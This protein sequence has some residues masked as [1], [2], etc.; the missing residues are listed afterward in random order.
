MNAPTPESK[1]LAIPALLSP[2]PLRKRKSVDEF[3]I[4]ALQA[5][6]LE[7]EST[8]S[9]QENTDYGSPNISPV[10]PDHTT[11]PNDDD[12]RS[13]KSS[14]QKTIE[15]T[16]RALGG[17]GTSKQIC[18]YISNHFPSEIRGKRNWKST[19]RTR[20]C[21]FF[22]KVPDREGEDGKTVWTLNDRSFDDL[23]NPSKAR[24][25]NARTSPRTS[26]RSSR[27]FTTSD[28]IHEAEGSD[29]EE[30]SKALASLSWPK[31]VQPT[32]E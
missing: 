4:K 28:L 7:E 11:H 13:A 30:A 9:S 19:V 24:M 5:A 14:Y 6:E 1:M 12:K 27:V 31:W 17:E 18:N 23:D 3:I 22:Q 29:I 25:R 2:E 20:L 21:Y 8:S 10:L 16:L 26:P 32:P 15:L